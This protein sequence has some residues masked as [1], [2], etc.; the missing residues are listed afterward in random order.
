M[1]PSAPVDSVSLSLPPPRLL[2]SETDRCHDVSS[3]VRALDVQSRPKEDIE[4][5]RFCADCVQQIARVS[6]KKEEERKH[7]RRTG[8]L[9]VIVGS[10][11]LIEGCDGLRFLCQARF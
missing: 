9:G 5:T 10:S 8:G 4:H 3:G 11:R 6:A 1:V 2:T 7:E